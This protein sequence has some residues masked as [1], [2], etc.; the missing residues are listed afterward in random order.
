MKPRAPRRRTAPGFSGEEEVDESVS[1]AMTYGGNRPMTPGPKSFSPVETFETE[2]GRMQEA[3]RNRQIAMDAS[4][5]RGA[6]PSFA[7]ELEGLSAVPQMGRIL[8]REES[9]TAAAPKKAVVDTGLLARTSKGMARG[10]GVVEVQKLLQDLNFGVPDEAGKLSELVAD[11]VYGKNTEAAVRSFQKSKAGVA[12]GLEPD[13]I[14]GP[15]TI[16]AMRAARTASAAKE[17][18]DTRPADTGNPVRSEHIRP[19]G[20]MEEPDKVFKRP[21]VMVD[22]EAEEMVSRT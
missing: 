12:A 8:S 13:G 19:L 15:K 22:E 6:F 20:P 5:S 18:R 17:Y 7:A 9:K 16:A 10:E 11:G 3:S 1:S 21:V 4:R 14:V 2:K